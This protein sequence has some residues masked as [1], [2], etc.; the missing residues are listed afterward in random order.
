MEISKG[1]AL[2]TS[3]PGVENSA[4]GCGRSLVGLRA[5]AWRRLS[6]LTVMRF[7]S[8][9]N[10]DRPTLGF[11]ESKNWK[12]AEAFKVR[13]LTGIG[14]VLKNYFGFLGFL[15]FVLDK[16]SLRVPGPNRIL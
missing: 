8:V 13:Q 12:G 3:Q 7:T 4:F 9:C 15:W 1:H 5:S 11:L 10:I 16:R 6:L 14:V 2:H